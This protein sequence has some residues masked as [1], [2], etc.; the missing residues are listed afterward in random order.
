MLNR[1]EFIG[2]LGKDPET[3]TTQAGK[4]VVNLT[5]AVS[6]RWKDKATGEQRDRT[7]W[8]NVVIWNEGLANVAE[9]YLRKGSKCYLAGKLQTRKW[10]DQTGQDRYSTE[11]VLDGFGGQLVLLGDPK[12]DGTP[13]RT[14]PT[15][16]S[17]GT[18]QP[19]P[20]AETS[21]DDDLDDGIPF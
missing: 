11:V 16:G 8:V 15:Y 2:N 21:L 12:G 10:Q 3:R 17:K 20:A 19:N 13:A 14:A 9:R 6:E 18:H 1:A 5:L 7:E 4:K